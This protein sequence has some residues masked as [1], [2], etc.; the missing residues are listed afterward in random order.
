MNLKSIIIISLLAFIGA[1]CSSGIKKLTPPVILAAESK[2]R[3]I[4]LKDTTGKHVAVPG[5]TPFARSIS[6]SY[7]PGDTVTTIIR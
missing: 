6:D 2:E 5:T 7:Q 4:V 1:S 3:D